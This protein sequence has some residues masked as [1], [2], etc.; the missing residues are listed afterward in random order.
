MSAQSINQIKISDTCDKID[1]FLI[2][3]GNHFRNIVDYDIDVKLDY[4][5]IKV[6]NW[7]KEMLDR[8]KKCDEVLLTINKILL[9]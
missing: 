2:C 7:L 5:K 4:K 1:S 6:I 3:E 8:T 9:K